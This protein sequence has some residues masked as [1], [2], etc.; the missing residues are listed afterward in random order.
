MIAKKLAYFV[1][2]VVMIFILSSCSSINDKIA[3]NEEG[4]IALT[5]TRGEK[6]QT[7]S[8]STSFV[9]S[10]Q[11]FS[12]ST[13]SGGRLM[14]SDEEIPR[15]T[16]TVLA[17]LEGYLIK[18]EGE[19]LDDIYEPFFFPDGETEVT[20]TF[21]LPAGRNYTVTLLA[22]GPEVSSGEEEDAKR[23]LLGAG[24]AQT[25][26]LDSE[27]VNQVYVPMLTYRYMFYDSEV[28]YEQD[29]QIG[30]FISGPLLD[31]I[32]I[33]DPE[34]IKG[35]YSLDP[36]ETDL[37]GNSMTNI[38]LEPLMDEQGYEY[39]SFTYTGIIPNPYIE[40]DYVELYLQLEFEIQPE[41]NQN[42]LELKFIVPSVNAGDT[43]EKVRVDFYG[44]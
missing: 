27:E 2:T 35:Y 25:V 11:A 34:S 38:F 15:T 42:G 17:L 31:E 1:L 30:L 36:M 6:A 20:V 18:I 44:V 41:W 19:G 37:S 26:V 13:G 24:R 29:L 5:L 14:E 22:L 7:T 8:C 21:D 10:G 33:L 43:F 4:T 39:S 16:D 28:P 32:L 23:L 40:V 9:P 3:L 12:S